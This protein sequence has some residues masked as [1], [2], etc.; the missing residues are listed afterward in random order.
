M[1]NMYVIVS[2]D[3]LLVIDP[4]GEV[5]ETLEVLSAFNPRKVRVLLTHG[6]LDHVCSVHVLKEKFNAEIMIHKDDYEMLTNYNIHREIDA[7]IPGYL[8]ACR[9]FKPVEPDLT[10]SDNYI[11]KFEE[12]VFRIIH[13]PGH[14]KGSCVIYCEDLDLAFTGDVVFRNGIG[15]I[16]TPHSSIQD[17]I[18]SIEKIINTLRR[19]TKILPGHGEE[20][21]LSNEL[22]FLLQVIEELKAL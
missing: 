11:V 17:M 9:S 13:T 15:R 7:T 6:H 16:D 10:L 4:G 14:T 3:E 5:E 21:T 1:T 12:H 22:E 2:S 18:S 20:T 19:S 8:S